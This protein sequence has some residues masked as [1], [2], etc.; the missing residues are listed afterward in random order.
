[1]HTLPSI[2]PAHRFHNVS[3]PTH[4]NRLKTKITPNAAPVAQMADAHYEME[5]MPEFNLP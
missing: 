3:V 5:E 4:D 1:V 2:P